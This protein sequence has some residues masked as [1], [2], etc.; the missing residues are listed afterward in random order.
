MVEIQ[1]WTEKYRPKKLDE[2]IG[3]ER[4]ISTLKNIV[5]K[6]VKVNMLF[7]GFP[8][9]GKTSTAYAFANELGLNVREFNAS[10]ERGIQTIREKIKPLAMSV[11]NI[12]ILLDEADNMTEDAQQALRRIM[13]K[14]NAW[15]VLTA[16]YEFGII[17]PIK[18]RCVIL[19]FE[20]LPNDTILNYVLKILKKEVKGYSNINNEDELKDRLMKLINYYN[21]DLRKILNR[22][23]SMV[24]NNGVL[25][26]EGVEFL[27][28]GDE[29]IKNI[30]EYGYKGDLFTASKY[31][32]EFL[33]KYDNSDII[34]D[35]ITKTALN[36]N[37][38]DIHKLKLISK[39]AEAE[40]GI[41]IGCNPYVQ[42][43]GLIADLMVLRYL[44]V[45]K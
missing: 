25:N 13:E 19:R 12:M 23:E 33:I 36:L 45:K 21:G 10:D 31:L 28:I 11:G 29:I 16:N 8:G 42:L 5:T 32:E 44:G 6:G 22:L 14:S 38:P 41:K 39:I 3:Q 7:I 27:E 24:G 1:M 35:R 4:V 17:D 18:S 30:F 15:F 26:L 34:F 37:I 20:K 40:R 9:V 43:M 2:I